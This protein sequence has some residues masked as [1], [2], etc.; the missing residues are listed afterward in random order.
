MV[1][2]EF[3]DVFFKTVGKELTD[4]LRD[5]VSRVKMALESR[6]REYV[7][8]KVKMED[9]SDDRMAEKIL[10]TVKRIRE[11]TEDKTMLP[12]GDILIYELKGKEAEGNNASIFADGILAF[13]KSFMSRFTYDE[14]AFVVGH[15]MAH[16]KLKH[17]AAI[18]KLDYLVNNGAEKS[19]YMR[20]QE[21]EADMLGVYYACK[22]G[23]N[24]TSSISALRK[25]DNM[26][27][28]VSSSFNYFSTHPTVAERVYYLR[29]NYSHDNAVKIVDSRFYERVMQVSNMNSF[30]GQEIKAEL[31]KK[32]NIPRKD[33]EKILD[34]CLKE[35]QEYM[36]KDATKAE[37]Q[38]YLDTKKVSSELAIIKRDMYKSK[39]VKDEI[40]LADNLI[41]K[42]MELPEVKK[43]KGL[44]VIKGVLK[45][46]AQGNTNKQWKGM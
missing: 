4:E 2:R 28:R 30:R 20:M 22:S 29:Q 39:F 6:L 13:S 31:V 18:P 16:Y 10:M 45:V 34:V 24:F 23:G 19:A 25:L 44:G 35:M 37:L 11:R 9:M 21:H 1:D 14:L 15:E 3:E 36:K 7:H 38:V 41:K 26:E 17:S 46:R 33:K 27:S 5:A 32:M 42:V 43:F 8:K 40:E 12:D